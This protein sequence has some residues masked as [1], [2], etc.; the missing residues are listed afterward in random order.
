MGIELKKPSER[1]LKLV[2]ARDLAHLEGITI[3]YQIKPFDTCG[4]VP[5]QERE[6]SKKK[7]PPKEALKL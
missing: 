7:K 3:T 1:D 5:L 4:R 2:G 6:P